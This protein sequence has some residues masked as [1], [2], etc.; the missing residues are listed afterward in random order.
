MGWLAQL[1]AVSALNI[2]TLKERA[3]SSAVA[4][5]GIAEVSKRRSATL[6]LLSEPSTVSSCAMPKLFASWPAR[7]SAPLF[8]AS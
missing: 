1:V 2:R 3:G 6:P 7:L 4:V 8:W 5:V